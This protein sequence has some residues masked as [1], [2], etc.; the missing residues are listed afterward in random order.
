MTFFEW[1]KKFID[2]LSNTSFY[3][4]KE[5]A[6][7]FRYFLSD[8]FDLRNFDDKVHPAANQEKT[9]LDALNRLSCGEPLQYITNVQYFYGY[10]FYVDPDVLIPRPE[11]EELVEKTLEVIKKRGCSSMIDIGTGSG[12]IAVT[13]KKKCPQI[14]MWAID[15]KDEIL[16]IA[17]RNSSALNVSDI[18]FQK[19]NIID[20]DQSETLPS[21]DLIVS[22]PPYI[23]PND[24]KFDKKISFE[25]VHALYTPGKNPLCF[26]LSIIQF[27]KEH[28]NHEGVI[29]VEINELYGSDCRD[30]FR[31][32]GYHTQLFQDLQGND[33]IILA[34]EKT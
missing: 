24:E 27:A 26:Y 5:A 12:C 8:A 20:Q 28:L 6:Q 25:P 9:I 10:Q 30:L 33:R 18:H 2:E 15:I 7:I 13:T 23:D 31:Q 11:T 16:D 21:F 22:N 19:C 3:N 17:I 1:K 14:A 32:K 29:L 34:T 4:K